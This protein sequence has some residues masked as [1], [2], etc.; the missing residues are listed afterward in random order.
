LKSLD[1]RASNQERLH[2]IRNRFR[3]LRRAAIPA[4]GGRKM[5]FVWTAQRY[6]IAVYFVAAFI[7][8]C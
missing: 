7:A 4:A 6:R 2:R 8:L 5:R 1:R 3:P